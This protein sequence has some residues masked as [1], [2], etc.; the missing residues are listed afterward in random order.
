MGSDYL[1][2]S[3]GQDPWPI[4]SFRKRGRSA[5]NNIENPIPNRASETRRRCRYLAQVARFSDCLDASSAYPFP[6]DRAVIVPEGS[7]TAEAAT[8]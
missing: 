2:R 7:A 8:A 6:S 3:V 5:K 1:T 4:F